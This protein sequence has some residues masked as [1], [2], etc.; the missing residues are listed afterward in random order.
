MDDNPYNGHVDVTVTWC[1]CPVRTV[2][3]TVYTV[4]TV[5]REKKPW[6]RSIFAL[7][8]PFIGKNGAKLLLN[9]GSWWI[10]WWTWSR[11]ISYNGHRYIRSVIWYK[12]DHEPVRFRDVTTVISVIRFLGV[13]HADPWLACV[14]QI[15]ESQIVPLVLL[16]SNAFSRGTV[17]SVRIWKFAQRYGDIVVRKLILKKRQFRNLFQDCCKKWFCNL[18]GWVGK[19]F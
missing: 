19:Q 11:S 8:G 4:W 1:R 7:K 16:L 6:F 10:P 9:H 12:A 18:D 13:N 5:I 3:L 14:Y 17:V 2:I 15:I